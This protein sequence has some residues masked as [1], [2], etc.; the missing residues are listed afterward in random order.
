MPTMLSF[1]VNSS[2][3]CINGATSRSLVSILTTTSPPRHSPTP[4][5]AAGRRFLPSSALA[6]SSSWPLRKGWNLATLM[7]SLS[8]FNS[9]WHP[10][11]HRRLCFTGICGPIT[12]RWVPTAPTSSTRPATGGTESAILPCCRCTLSSRRKFTTGTSLFP[13]CRPVSSIVNRCISF[14]R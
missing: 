3:A 4:G 11:S 13:L 1:S 5:S 9:V 14:I 12:A 6:G 2:R 10:T 8:M 7:P